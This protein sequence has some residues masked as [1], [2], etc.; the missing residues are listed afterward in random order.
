ME[1]KKDVDPQ[2]VLNRIE[3]Q[4]KPILDARFKSYETITSKDLDTQLDAK[5]DCI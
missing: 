2:E 5:H 3:E 4:L 1:I